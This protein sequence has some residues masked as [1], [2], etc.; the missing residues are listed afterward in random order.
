M[1]MGRIGEFACLVAVALLL[2]A[3]GTSQLPEMVERGDREAAERVLDRAVEAHGGLERWSEIRDIV[4]RYE[5]EWASIG[6]RIQPVLADTGYRRKSV[7][8]ILPA[9]RVVGQLHEG[10]SGEKMVHRTPDSID[11]SYD[12]VPATSGDV[13]DAAALVADVYQMFLTTPFFYDAFATSA[14]WAGT[15][16]IDGELCDRISA[17]V[18][19]GFG[20]ADEDLAVISIGRDTG[21]LRR[22]RFTLNGVESTRGAEVDVTFRGHREIDGILWATEYV[23]RIRAPFK[24]AAHEWRLVSLETNTGKDPR[25]SAEWVPSPR[26]TGP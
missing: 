22:V 8:V 2:P 4:V 18:R 5:G 21:I 1:N 16:W 20:R 17:V 26:R 7:E 24:L 19:P 15:E 25:P 6:P 11:V 3:C 10:P 9:R 14:R 13:L 12:G 23:E